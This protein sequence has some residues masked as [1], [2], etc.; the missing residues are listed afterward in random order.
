L[1]I[2]KTQVESICIQQLQY[3][4]VNKKKAVCSAISH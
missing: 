2:N 4:A 1:E 3:F